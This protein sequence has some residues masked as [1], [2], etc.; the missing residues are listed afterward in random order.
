M[1]RT[2]AVLT[3]AALLLATL[4]AALAKPMPAATVAEGLSLS[5]WVVSAEYTGYREP[6][7]PPDYFGGVVALY[8][9]V[10]VLQ[11]A[12]LTGEL[13]VG[14]GF[15]DGSACLAPPGWSFAQERMPTP[16]TRFLLLLREYDA[17]TGTYHAY[18]GSFGHLEESP[19]AY[20]ELLRAAP[21]EAAVGDL[22]VRAEAALWREGTQTS[23]PE[24]SSIHARVTLR[25][26]GGR[27]LPAALT[28]DRLWL[29]RDAE[30]WSGE[31]AAGA[32]AERALRGGPGWPAGK[33]AVAV[34]RLRAP[35]GAARLLR[36]GECT[37]ERRTPGGAAAAPESGD[38]AGTR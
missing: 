34:V 8:R 32:G 36:I 18:R 4:T 10:E 28:A 20:G 7:Q 23:P 33:P 14:Y 26:E 9:V 11:G 2:T 6:A 17:P 3:A 16:G 27:E 30:V 21:T 15:H 24:G 22:R 1:S 31:F 25:A 19:T 29:L 38:P 37:V 13:A 12:P 35:D 5:T